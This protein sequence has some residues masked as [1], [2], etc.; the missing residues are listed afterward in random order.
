MTEKKEQIENVK[1]IFEPRLDSNHNI[2]KDAPIC[3]DLTEESNYEP[4]KKKIVLNSL[5]VVNR[6]ADQPSTSEVG[7]SRIFQ[8]KHKRESC[9][10]CGGQET[11]VIILDCNHRICYVCLV[12][13]LK[14][15]QTTVNIC[16]LHKCTEEISNKVIKNALVPADYVCFLEHTIE[17]FNK[18]LNDLR[19]ETF[20]TKNQDELKLV[21]PNKSPEDFHNQKVIDLDSMSPQFSTKDHRSEFFHLQNLE[22]ESYVKNFEE[23]DCPICFDVIAIGQGVILKSCLH[24]FCIECLAESVK[25]S[26]EPVVIC[27]FNSVQGNCEFSIQEREIRAIVSQEI[28]EL[29]LTK[30]LKQGEYNLENIFH[31]K[32]PDCIG[33]IQ[34]EGIVVAYN[35]EVCGM[36]NCIKCAAIH[37]NKD[38]K[39]YQDDLKNAKNHKDLL[40]TTNA[41]K[42]M[43]ENDEVSTSQ[44]C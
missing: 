12:L 7:P 43:I 22:A 31:C 20:K 11:M 32:T 39:Q 26:E 28:Y 1:E 5:D 44:N 8:R 35:C 9:V 42:A 38:C 25:H 24:S 41:L 33:F 40:L 14:L 15:S 36:I 6:I 29:H 30:A 19:N 13:S 18:T 17:I 27:P 23:F 37:E 10:K 3:I 2:R 21:S 4:V 34:Y 16:P